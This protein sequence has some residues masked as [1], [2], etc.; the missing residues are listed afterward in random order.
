[1]IIK[2]GG[3]LA[4]WIMGTYP[5]G[6]MGLMGREQALADRS[7]DSSLLQLGLLPAPSRNSTTQIFW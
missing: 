6:L 3:S 7:D 4:I 1:M 2:N 5:M